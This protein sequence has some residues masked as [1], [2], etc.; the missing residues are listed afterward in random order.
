MRLC[1]CT[2]FL[3]CVCYMNVGEREKEL[4]LEKYFLQLLDTDRGRVHEL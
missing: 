2:T 1:G 3:K 4:G